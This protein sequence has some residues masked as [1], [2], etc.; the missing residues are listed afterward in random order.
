MKIISEFTSVLAFLLFTLQSIHVDA[1]I[2]ETVNVKV[3][4]PDYRA[5]EDKMLAILKNADLESHGY[6]K[7]VTSRMVSQPDSGKVVTEKSFLF[8]KIVDCSRTRL[9]EIDQELKK[10]LP[11][12][13]VAKMVKR[14]NKEIDTKGLTKMK[15]CKVGLEVHFKQRCFDENKT[16]RRRKRGCNWC[17]FCWNASF[18]S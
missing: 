13:F 10:L 14:I 8:Y 1:T 18:Y 3:F 5:S 11:G 12:V 6:K 15:Q 7:E 16:V 2:E 9:R 4:N 17:A